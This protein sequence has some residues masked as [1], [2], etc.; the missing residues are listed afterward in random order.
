[1][2]VYISKCSYLGN[3]TK[4]LI[5]NLLASFAKGFCLL[6][7]PTTKNKLN[8]IR[9]ESTKT[10]STESARHNPHIRERTKLFKQICTAIRT[11]NFQTEN[12]F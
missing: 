9:V 12:L 6:P 4:A 10:Q 2:T 5:T 3:S 1:M 8:Q 7:I 11:N